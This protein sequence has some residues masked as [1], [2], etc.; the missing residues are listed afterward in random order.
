MSRHPTC[1]KYKHKT[2]RTHDTRAINGAGEPLR[3]AAHSSSSAD[4]KWLPVRHAVNRYIYWLQYTMY[5]IWTHS[6][7]C[8]HLWNG[9]LTPMCD[10]HSSAV[11][12]RSKNTKQNLKET[13]HQFTAVIKLT[14]CVSFTTVKARLQTVGTKELRCSGLIQLRSRLCI[15][16]QVQYSAKS[17]YNQ[18]TAKAFSEEQY[19]LQYHFGHK[20]RVSKSFSLINIFRGSSSNPA[21]IMALSYS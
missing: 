5:T 16:R 17:T 8:S 20:A 14:C 15:C 4:D 1:T 21:P 19:Q 3:L 13:V 18:T 7:W 6:M 2:F 10:I 9:Y 12:K 11:R